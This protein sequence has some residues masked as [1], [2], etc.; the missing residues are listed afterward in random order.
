[1][2]HLFVRCCIVGGGPAGMMLGYLLARQ[3]VDVVVLEKHSNFLRDFRGDTLHPSTLE[4]MGEMGLDEELLAI[5]HGEIPRLRAALGDHEVTIADFRH[6][7]TRYKFIAMMPQWDF[8]NFLA[9]KGRQHDGFALRM[10]TEVTD[11]A[12]ENG[13]VV[14]VRA[15]SPQGDL[16]V[17]AHLVVGCDGRHSLVRQKAGLVIK[18][19][20]APID[21][22]WFRLTRKP[23]DPDEAL[24]RAE[25]GRAFVLINRPE[26]WQCG[27]VIP[28]GRAEA[29]RVRG[30]PAFRQDVARLAPFLADRV[31]D[32]TSWNDVPV[33]SV[34]VDRLER[35]Y[36]EGLLCIGDAAHAMSPIG[37]VGINL[38]VQDAVATANRLAEPLR[39][40]APALEDL[41]RVQQRREWPTRLTQRFQ[42]LVQNRGLSPLVVDE[43][44]SQ[45][46]PW[47]V[48]LL[49]RLA[50]FSP[51]PRIT[52]RLIG[53]GLRPEH[54]L[55]SARV[56]S[57]QTQ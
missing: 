35:W 27:F 11:L 33:L 23:G 7:P 22:L 54:V 32:I 16:Q 13:T 52:G 56:A 43:D 49:A 17:R 37:G 19:L 40:G 3:G 15:H 53:L 31:G 44:E 55:G 39:A 51:L 20:G 36:R 21:V 1:M 41:R 48:S 38:A 9:Q 8:L 29:W 6:L 57:E 46:L 12:Q 2:E 26:H 14:G 50:R 10:Q 45:S 28:K 24:G 47:V 30:L 34:A 25:P 42:L 5:P 4:L 18:E